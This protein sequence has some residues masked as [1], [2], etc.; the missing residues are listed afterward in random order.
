MSQ[1]SIK[2]PVKKYNADGKGDKP[3]LTWRK[4]SYFFGGSHKNFKEACPTL[5]KTCSFCKSRN[6][7]E[8]KCHKKKSVRAVQYDD[9]EDSDN[10]QWLAAVST[11]KKSR[12]TV[13]MMINDN[14]VR[15][16]VDTAADVNIICQEH[17]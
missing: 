10:G 17:V 8:T 16:Q 6:H 2:A 15:F 3:Q 7:F 5:G 13:L 1:R 11:G 14:D 9:S 12:I 4:D